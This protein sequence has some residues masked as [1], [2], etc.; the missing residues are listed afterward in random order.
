MIKIVHEL[1]LAKGSN[2]KKEILRKHQ[3]NEAW[4]KVLIAMYDSS[5]NY[6]T[7]CPNDLTFATD[8][9]YV[10]MLW[11]LGTLV[12]RELTG[13]AARDYAKSLSIKYGELLR[14]VLEGSLKSGVGIETINAIYPGLIPT[15]PLMK[16]DHYTVERW[17]IWASIKYDG[18][19][20][21]AT[22]Y[23]N[24]ACG[25]MV[26]LQT[27]SGRSIQINSLILAMSQQPIGVYDGELVD[28]DGKQVSRTKITGK[29]NKCLLGTATDIEGYTYCIFDKVSQEE[30][31]AKVSTTPFNE[32]LHNLW[33]NH[34]PCNNILLVKH[35][36]VYN[37]EDLTTMYDDLILLG[38]E[39]L[40][41][42]Y[43]R[44]VYVWKRSDFV[45]KQKAT[46]TAV[47]TCMAIIPGKGKFEGV[48][49]S[50]HCEG[51]VDG[52]Y[53]VVSAGGMSD[54]ARERDHE[55][56][57]NKR[58]EI[59]YNSITLAEGADYHSLFLPRYKRVYGREDT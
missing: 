36:P 12:R 53:V 10:D 58:V 8:V 57:L 51:E 47:L 56:Y 25:N 48:I 17:P 39:G 24:G 4:K 13:N 49:G 30:W 1:R 3:D 11:D 44:D 29:M 23:D 43:L 14:L 37:Q 46:K 40:M 16:G 32:R 42:R 54:F 18:A 38:Y 15:F 19:R 52:N 27:S 26:K 7:G 59:D 5:I 50:L 20:L 31:D 35:I 9:N 41:G 45:I 2:K 21:I 34:S 22:V 6:Y 55:Y 28:G 33:D